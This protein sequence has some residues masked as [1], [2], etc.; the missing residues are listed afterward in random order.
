MSEYY[1]SMFALILQ[2]SLA[3]STERFE[4][5]IGCIRDV[6]DAWRQVA[7]DPEVN[8]GTMRRDAS[9]RTVHLGAQNADSQQA[10]SW[11]A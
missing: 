6:R 10:S 1:A 9:P 11:T 4:Q 2:A 5:V 8:A 3:A 7:A